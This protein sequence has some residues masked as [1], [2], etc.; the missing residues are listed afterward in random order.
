VERLEL[1]ER[2]QRIRDEEERM[3][4]EQQRQHYQKA[5]HWFN[6]EFRTKVSLPRSR[7]LNIW[8]RDV[9]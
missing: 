5:P 6:E 3:R 1:Q 8:A 4:E 7:R 9:H 2:L